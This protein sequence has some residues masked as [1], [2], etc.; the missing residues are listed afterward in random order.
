MPGTATVYEQ[1]RYELG[2]ASGFRAWGAR[3]MLSV[4][5]EA[6]EKRHLDFAR[7]I[8]KHP[9]HLSFP[10][11]S[12]DIARLAKAADTL[13]DDFLYDCIM[14][15]PQIPDE[16]TRAYKPR[17]F[18]VNDEGP[19]HSFSRDYRIRSGLLCGHLTAN[20]RNG[21]V[22]ESLRIINETYFL[23]AKPDLFQVD[24]WFDSSKRRLG[25]DMR[26]LD[27]ALRHHH[28]HFWIMHEARAAAATGRPAPLLA[29]LAR[30]IDTHASAL[31]PVLDE[32]CADAFA[33]MAASAA[34]KETGGCPMSARIAALRAST[35][36]KQTLTN[37]SR[38]HAIKRPRP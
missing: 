9:D 25:D 5:C 19:Y 2:V 11:D 18:S 1:I 24:N 26:V 3:E 7:D 16:L 35:R 23:T 33:L 17:S 32:I 15:A 6:L 14:F 20:I 13:D 37:I 36:Q 8:L 21:L 10:V 28:M 29:A 34:V 12:T 27:A 38:T 22:D 31:S 30:N 4:L